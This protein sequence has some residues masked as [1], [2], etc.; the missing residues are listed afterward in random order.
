MFCRYAIGK[1]RQVLSFA[2]TVPDIAKSC[3]YIISYREQIYDTESTVNVLPRTVRVNA[4]ALF[5]S[6][7]SRITLLWT[8]ASSRPALG[9]CVHLLPLV[10]ITIYTN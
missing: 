8:L 4:S 6:S 2:D 3:R 10:N 7:T 5:G 1:Y 9:R